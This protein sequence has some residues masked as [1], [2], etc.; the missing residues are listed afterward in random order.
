MPDNNDILNAL[1]GSPLFAPP[2]RGAGM[3]PSS[4]LNMLM[5][6][7]KRPMILGGR[8]SPAT[9]TGGIGPPQ[10]RLQSLSP[11]LARVPWENSA[12]DLSDTAKY[13][14]KSPLKTDLGTKYPDFNTYS[15]LPNA[16]NYEKSNTE[17]YNY[18]VME[19][20]LRKAGFDPSKMSDV[21]KVVQMFKLQGMWPS[22]DDN[23]NPTK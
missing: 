6:Q 9:I 1:K 12:K 10:G 4:I 5:M 14:L 13:D 17:K 3:D 11:N 15:G 18:A 21:E 19:Q 7:N 20:T 8:P 23:N 2:T 16:A 22:P